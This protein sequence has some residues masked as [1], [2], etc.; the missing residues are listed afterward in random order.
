MR[1][2]S[3]VL[4]GIAVAF[5]VIAGVLLITLSAVALALRITGYWTTHPDHIV[6]CGTVLGLLLGFIALAFA[7][8]KL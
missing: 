5:L 4:K 6:A 8:P 7:L 3:R 1:F 2:R